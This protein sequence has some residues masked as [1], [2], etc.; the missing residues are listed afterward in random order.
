MKDTQG[1]II[2]QGDIYWINF[3]PSVGSEIKKLRP[4]LVIQDQNIAGKSNTIL[5]CPIISSENTHPFDVGLRKS[6]LQEYSRVRCI[7]VTTCDIS[8]FLNYSGTISAD[9]FKNVQE[10][11]LLLLGV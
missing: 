4:A 8:R 7:Q 6:F 11:I 1:R 10:R 5:I 2:Q 9:N 3:D